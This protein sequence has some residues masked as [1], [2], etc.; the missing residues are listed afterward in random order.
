MLQ[1]LEVGAWQALMLWTCIVTY[2]RSLTT[3][4]VLLDVKIAK[5]RLLKVKNCIEVEGETCD[6]R[7][8]SYAWEEQR[9]M[10]LLQ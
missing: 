2:T 5:V 1:W 9:Q 10:R 3:F 7:G 4:T 8:L 6:E